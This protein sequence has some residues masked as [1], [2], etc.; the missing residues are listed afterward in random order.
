MVPYLYYQ[1]GILAESPLNFSANRLAHLAF[2]AAIYNSGPD[3]QKATLI[4][5]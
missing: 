4:I 2:L 5:S 3:T 1:A